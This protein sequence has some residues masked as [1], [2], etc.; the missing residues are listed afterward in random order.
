[1]QMPVAEAQAVPQV[2]L[3]VFWAHLP[4]KNVNAAAKVRP[5]P[6]R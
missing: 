5:R 4:K 2:L 6:A 3:V 1:M